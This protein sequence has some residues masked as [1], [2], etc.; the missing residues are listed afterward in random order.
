MCLNLTYDDA[1]D[2]IK[3]ADE[4]MREAQLNSKNIPRDPLFRTTRRLSRQV[5]EIDS[6]KKRHSGLL[7]DALLCAV[8]RLPG[9]EAHRKKI[10]IGNGRYHLIFLAYNHGT[11]KLYVFDCKRGHGTYDS[12]AKKSIDTRLT[13]VRKVILMYVRKLNWNPRA[14][15]IST[16]IIRFYENDDWR[17]AHTLYGKEDIAKLFEPCVGT[18]ISRYMEYIELKVTDSYAKKSNKKR[19]IPIRRN[20]FHKLKSRSKRSVK[21]INFNKDRARIVP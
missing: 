6:I 3:R 2:W 21:S 13:N 8:K 1:N 11:R 16:F 10:P 14:R 5:S 20:I 18:F 19:K 7:R 9:W 4:V 15:D 17:P 12:G